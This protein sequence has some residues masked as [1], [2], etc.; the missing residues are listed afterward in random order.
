LSAALLAVAVLVLAMPREDGFL[1]PE[2]R[3]W[4]GWLRRL[5][6][7]FRR[8]REE[9]AGREADDYVTDLRTDR[10]QDPMTVRADQ[11]PSASRVYRGPLVSPPTG[12]KPPWKTSE[13]PAWTSGANQVLP[14]EAPARAR[15]RAPGDPPTIVIEIMRPAI[16][17]DLGYY[18][19]TLPAYP[20]DS[21]GDPFVPRSSLALGAPDHEGPPRDVQGDQ[22]QEDDLAPLQP[23]VGDVEHQEKPGGEESPRDR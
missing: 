15:R 14:P 18:L 20:D 4:L 10:D 7:G 17:G 3:D 9:A 5:R 11:L 19:T 2:R 22:G 13:N 16:E 8:K 12:K 1:L 6:P 21:A 23:R